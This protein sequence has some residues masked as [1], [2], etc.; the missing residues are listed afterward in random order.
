MKTHKIFHKKHTC[1]GCNSC[2]LMA[3]QTWEM[4][5]K[6]GKVNLKNSRKTGGT[7]SEQ[8]IY[9]ADLLN[10]D[11]EDNINATAACPMNCIRIE[12]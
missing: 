11:L 4:D 6:T 2:V 7:Q 1:I 3:G 9:T 5:E 8:E 12:K 10:F